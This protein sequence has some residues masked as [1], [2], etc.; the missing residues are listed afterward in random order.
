MKEDINNI[1]VM[2]VAVL[3]GFFGSFY[4]SLYMQNHLLM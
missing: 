1:V 3:V 2:V 4:V